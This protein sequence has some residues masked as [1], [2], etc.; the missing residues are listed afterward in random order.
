MLLGGLGV[1]RDA[2]VLGVWKCTPEAEE[3]PPQ[4]CTKPPS[5]GE[6]YGSA[7]SGW[8]GFRSQRPLDVTSV[9][10]RVDSAAP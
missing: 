10:K 3:A 5:W 8:E 9:C 4:S 6:A 2:A 1:I 7:S